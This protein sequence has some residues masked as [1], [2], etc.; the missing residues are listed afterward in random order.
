M[1]ARK[2]ET[3]ALAVSLGSRSELCC[4]CVLPAPLAPGRERALRV[5]LD[6]CRI[7][8]QAHA[9]RCCEGLGA[10]Q[11]L[12]ARQMGFFLNHGEA[13]KAK[14]AHQPP[15][16]ARFLCLVLWPNSGPAQHVVQELRATSFQWQVAGGSAN[17]AA[18]P[19]LA[20]MLNAAHLTCL[21]RRPSAG[22]QLPISLTASPYL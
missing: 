1:A 20:H 5:R 15:L 10:P 18:T 4:C 2:A 9:G 8:R 3:T 13:C 11:S 6:C 7:C 22:M 14:L 19:L 16:E 12:K 21:M 17:A